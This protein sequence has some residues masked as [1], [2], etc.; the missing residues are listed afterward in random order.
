MN[1]SG[2][3]KTWQRRF[4]IFNG[5]TE[6]VSEW[7]SEGDGRRE[8]SS[9][10]ICAMDK[11]GVPSL[12][13]LLMC[14]NV[15]MCKFMCQCVCCSQTFLLLLYTVLL[16]MELCLNLKFVLSRIPSLLMWERARKFLFYFYL[17]SLLL[18]FFWRM[19][20]DPSTNMIFAFNNRHTNTHAQFWGR[21]CYYITHVEIV[22]T[23]YCTVCFYDWHQWCVVNHVMLSYSMFGANMHKW[24]RDLYNRS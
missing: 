10:H 19:R 7:V 1:F 21:W 11:Q 5:E 23:Q 18:F 4:S 24:L 22:L 15:C 13:M 3:I 6:W 2:I 8:N 17:F 20:V 14:I 16:L 9:T 12:W